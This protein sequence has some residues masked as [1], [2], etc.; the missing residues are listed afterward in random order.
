M[1]VMNWPPYPYNKDQLFTDFENGCSFF[2]VSP[3]ALDNEDNSEV[4]RHCAWCFADIVQ[5]PREK[6]DFE[7]YI[8]TMFESNKRDFIEAGKDL[9]WISNRIFDLILQNCEDLELRMAYI[10]YMHD[11]GFDQYNK[12]EI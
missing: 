9:V 2:G 4:L 8:R 3:V 11:S 12:F 1:K 6:W 7:S 5:M 10:R